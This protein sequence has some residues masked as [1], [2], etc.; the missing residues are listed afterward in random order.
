MTNI[1]LQF[2]LK[3]HFYVLSILSGILVGTSYIPYP[4]W[5][6]F[7]CYIPLWYALIQSEKQKI[8][9]KE[10]FF[11]AWITQFIYT[12][13]GFNWIA[14]TAMEFGHLSP[15]LSYSA[16]ILFAAFIH[17]HIPISMTL[18]TWLKRRFSLSQTQHIFTIAIVMALIERV[19]PSIFEWNLAYV[20]LWMRWPLFQWADTVGFLGLSAFLLVAQSVLL[21]ATYAFKTS[22]LKSLT[23][24]LGLVTSI[25]L[26]NWTGLLKEKKWSQTD[27]S[28]R[29]SIT[30][31]N[32]GNEE[33]LLSELGAQFRPTIVGKYVDQVDEYLAENQLP[34]IILWPETAMPLALDDHLLTYPLQARILTK[35]KAW[36]TILITG[37]FSH[38]QIKK[39]HLGT[40][41]TRNA[42]FFIGPNGP[43]QPAYHKSQLLAF[44]EYLPLGETFPFLYKLLPFVGTFEKGPGPVIK[45]VQLKSGKKINL[46]PQI[47]YESLD[48]AF[49]RQ[50]AKKGAEIIFNVTN[51]SW[52]GDW[53]EPYQHMVMTLARGIET[54][55]PLVRSTNTGITTVILANGSE[56]ARSPI[57]KR[58]MDSYDVK[59]L[60]QAPQSHYTTWGHFDWLILVFSLVFI[61]WSGANVRK[62]K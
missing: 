5:G 9:L 14:Y 19:W 15:L 39:D 61:L 56:L 6:I 22:K 60:S 12:I 45:T 38:D 25:G 31:G 8:S 49:S 29:F 16:L 1:L 37:A 17:I 41:L 34:D 7:F 50:L 18:A 28:I 3:Y 54:R 21:T 58:W 26:L 52:F 43:V 24:V 57:N 36:D 11:L 33:K 47:C 62:I 13:I 51:D 48:P 10:Q 40:T 27:S 32:V 55:R 59:Y 30:Q 53:A 46:G 42:I 20:F 2:K 44:G 23:L 4:A 35:V